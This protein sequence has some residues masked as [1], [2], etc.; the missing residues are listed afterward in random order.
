MAA[1][2]VLSGWDE[3]E[4]FNAS[5]VDAMAEG[6]D[7]ARWNVLGRERT[8]TWAD[9]VMGFEDLA[10]AG[11][12]RNQLATLVSAQLPPDVSTVPHDRPQEAVKVSVGGRDLPTRPIHLVPSSS[13]QPGRDLGATV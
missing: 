8:T 12:E 10:D 9:A 6:A 3:A 13:L 5:Q 7:A 2:F 11:G 4:G 1:R